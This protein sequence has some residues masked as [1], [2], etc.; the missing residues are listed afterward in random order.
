MPKSRLEEAF[1]DFN[2]AMLVAE[3][4]YKKECVEA[5][6]GV[7]REALQRL[8]DAREWDNIQS[9]WEVVGRTK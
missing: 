9:V 7:A 4:L 5:A 1:E 8:N 2:V 6:D 3:E